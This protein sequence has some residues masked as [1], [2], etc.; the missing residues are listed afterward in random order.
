MTVRREN[1]LKKFGCE[2]ECGSL[3]EVWGQENIFCWFYFV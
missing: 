2:V 1:S 3:N